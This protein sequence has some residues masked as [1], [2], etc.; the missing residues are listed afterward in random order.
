MGDTAYPLGLDTAV[1]GMPG[2]V[3]HSGH[4]HQLCPLAL[5]A[6]HVL[7]FVNNLSSGEFRCEA[8]L[9]C[10][11]GTFISTISLSQ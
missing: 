7:L 5:F 10:F 2:S 4:T 1:V 8:A 3:C 11:K 9:E 6:L